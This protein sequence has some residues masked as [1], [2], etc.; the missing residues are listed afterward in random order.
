MMK[1]TENAQLGTTPAL[2][3]PA[4]LEKIDKLFACNVGEHINLPQLVVVGDQSSGKSS[5]LEGLT[6]LKFPR[7]SGLCT[8]FAT[9]IIFRRAPDLATRKVNGSIISSTTHNEGNEAANWSMSDIE[10]LS[11][12]EFENMMDEVHEAMGLSTSIHDGL[13][14]FS[15]DVLRLE[16]HGPQENHLSVIDVPGIFKTTTPGLTT[17]SDIVLVRDMVLNYMRNPRSIMLAVVPANVDIATQEIIEIARELD[18]DGQR[19]LRILTKPDLVDEGAEDKIIELVERNPET[20]GLGWVVVKNLGQKDLQD[21]SKIRDIEE[22]KFRN[23]P[24]WNRLS[25]ENYGIEALGLRLQALLASNVRR[26]FPKVRFEVTKRLK[27][28]RKDLESLGSE[29]ESPEQQSRYLLEVV[30]KFQR[31]TENAL[32]TN[33]GSQDFF[34]EYPSLRLATLVANR[35]AQ[36]SEELS[37]Q[38]HV[39]CFKAHDHD[40]D[41][42]TDPKVSV[43]STPNSVGSQVG[44]D[45]YE[46]KEAY[47]EL[48]SLPSR[49]IDICHDIE[50]ILHDGV[51]IDLLS[52]LDFSRQERITSAAKKSSFPVTMHDGSSQDCYQISDLVQVHD[53][54][55]SEQTVEDIHDILKSYYKVARKRFVDNVCMQAADFH[56]VT[57][58]EAPMNIFSP[59]WV[60]CLT[61]EQ[62]EH[63]A[64]E[65]LSIRRKR[66]RLQKETKDLEAGRKILH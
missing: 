6:K 40:D 57:G 56:L 54:S 11:E 62:L 63:I 36:F 9:Q 13:P 38:G 2:A 16:I 33:Y 41:S 32:R 55:N 51:Q 14:T 58:P 52:G 65:E 49:K 61:D 18:P 10:A 45:D 3:D 29:R 43:I 23:S 53:M 46:D 1:T 26:E 44:E 22:D 21:T 7:N 5:V 25:K 47:D 24:P 34:D 30:S 50:D 59:S 4:L 28:C 8:R 35:N 17:K 60:Y 12:G 20:Q 31:I 48:N 27:E 64:G 66:H 15:H 39:Y 42:E 19:T 37:T